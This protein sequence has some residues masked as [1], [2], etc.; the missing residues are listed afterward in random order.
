MPAYLWVDPLVLQ[1]LH[2]ESLAQHGGATGMRDQGAF[3][4]A[5]KRPQN[6]AHYNDQADIADLAAC[7]A[8]GLVKNHPFVDGNKRAAFLSVGIFLGINGYKLT[9]S[10]AG[11]IHAV[12][13]LAGSHMSEQA[14]AHWLRDHITIV[15]SS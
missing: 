7:Y 6:S 14:F 9:A 11:A 2:S 15:Q 3:D 13:D 4:S 10:P 8:H 12:T 1:M 5:M